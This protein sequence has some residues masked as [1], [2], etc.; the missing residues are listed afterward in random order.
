MRQSNHKNLFPY[1]KDG[2]TVI[3]IIAVLVMI[4]VIS[5]IILGR[6]G[7]NIK[8]DLDARTDTLKTHLRYA[9]SRAMDSDLIWGIRYT[10][11]GY[12]LFSFNGS[13]ES[14][15]RI[16]DE[17]NVIVDLSGDGISLGTFQAI[18]YDSWGS[19]YANATGTGSSAGQTIVVSAGSAPPNAI[20]VTKNTGFIQ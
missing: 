2:F 14:A 7:G 8:A 5:A 13:S 15:I 9:Q 1:S 10:G 18:S 4:S 17:E 20:A 16:P 6:L 3:E 12:F 11:T 19:P